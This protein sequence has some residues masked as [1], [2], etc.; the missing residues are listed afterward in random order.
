MASFVKAA[1]WTADPPNHP[2]DVTYDTT[3][4]PSSKAIILYGRMDPNG[5]GD[6]TDRDFTGYYA[7]AQPNGGNGG[8]TSFDSTAQANVWYNIVWSSASG[9]AGHPGFARD[10]DLGVVARTWSTNGLCGTTDIGSY[11]T[12]P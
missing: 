7:C 10:P 11:L 9:V 8:T 4:C 2:I 12:C 6:F 1:G 3:R 5:D